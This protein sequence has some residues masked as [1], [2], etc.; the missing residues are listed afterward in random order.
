MAVFH[1]PGYQISLAEY[2]DL[3]T[4]GPAAARW[5]GATRRFLHLVRDFVLV[6]AGDVR[7]DSRS[8]RGL[9]CDIRTA[10]SLVTAAPGIP[11]TIDATITNTG[12]AYW[13]A[14]N[15]PHGGV[16]L[17]AHVYD[18]RGVLVVFEGA[19]AAL[20]NPPR[21]IAPNDAVTCRMTLP[22]LA[23]GRYQVELDCVADR[24]TWFAQA[25][26]PPAIVM[27]EVKP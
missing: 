1:E 23:P 19:R 12:R 6:K 5:L 13:L 17:G 10:Q 7:A 25:G 27:I 8:A 24:V 18:E 20:T 22:A 2:E 16:S 9:S 11:A 21:D 3:S 15:V 4:G 14:S 26:S